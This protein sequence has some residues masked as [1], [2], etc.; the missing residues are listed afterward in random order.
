MT[1]ITV[2]YKTVVSFYDTD[3]MGVAWHGHYV[4]F[5]EDAR[6]AL[7]DVIGHDYNDMKASGYAW[8]VVQL[9]V[10]YMKPL[11][12]KQ[13][14]NIK[15]TLVEFENCIKVTYLITD[16]DTGDKL[17][18]AETMQ[19]AVHVDSGETCMVSPPAFTD[20]VRVLLKR[21]CK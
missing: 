21:T 7:L 17:S 10:K 11:I 6:C 8:P 4:R 18:K 1:H 2:N 15:T 3:S 5:L 13:K 12:F 16:A 19:M 9:H 14:I 20:K